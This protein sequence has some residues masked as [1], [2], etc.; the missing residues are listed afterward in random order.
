MKNIKGR[1]FEDANSSGNIT[2]TGECIPCLGI[3][4]DQNLNVVTAIIANKVCELAAPLDLSTLSLQGALD[5][6]NTPEPAN[7]TL[8]N[9]LQL[10]L[11]NEVGL[12]ELIDNIQ[13]Q[14]DGISTTHL[15]LDLKCLKQVDSFGNTL[16][17]TNQ[18]VLQS[19]IN[20][21]CALD[22]SVADLS[23]KY[24]ALK[25][26]VDN[27]DIP[28][29]DEP[30]VTTCISGPK[31]V[32]LSLI[33]VANDYCEYKQ[34]VGTATQIQTAIARQVAKFNTLM[35]GIQGWVVPS[36]P[37]NFSLAQSVSNMW[38]LLDNY[39]GRISANELCCGSSCDDVVIGFVSS[40][41][42]SS[43]ILKFT[44]GAGTFIPIGFTDCGSILTITDEL[45]TSTSVNIVISQGGETD[46]IDLSMFSV[47]SVLDFNIDLKMCSA[48]ITCQ[49]CI[50]K[51]V[52]YVNSS[53]CVISNT[54]SEP[55]TVV[56]QT[57]A[58]SNI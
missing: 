10:C 34:D 8:T 24:T 25:N 55:I 48:N 47:G 33:D 49:K 46:E 1:G 58:N 23:G 43:I 26:K 40:I 18:S 12:K 19:L 52:K 15:V 35:S 13:D 51:N 4:P 7:R 42:G 54:G 5:I 14:I 50:N 3:K 36:S 38:L 31:E 9:V 22:S 57:Y 11:D 32:S 41:E 39:F 27:L 37:S 45:G 17:Y 2:W 56:Y 30:L 28:S 44:S 20:E 53:C 29:G 6:F 21:V 16:P